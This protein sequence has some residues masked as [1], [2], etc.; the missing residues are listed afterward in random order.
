VTG[1]SWLTGVSK[2]FAARTQEKPGTLCEVPGFFVITLDSSPGRRSGLLV[3]GLW[4][5]NG[6]SHELRE[7]RLLLGL[8]L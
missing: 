7:S 5:G 4:K 6:E 3:K 8:V 1:M 2:L